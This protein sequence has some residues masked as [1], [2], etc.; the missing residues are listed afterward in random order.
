MKELPQEY[1][2]EKEAIREGYEKKV[3]KLLKPSIIT[4]ASALILSSFF[5]IKDFTKLK[6]LQKNSPIYLEY[7]DNQS[8]LKYLRNELNQ[9]QSEEF[10][11]FLSQNIKNELEEITVLDTTKIP[12]LEKLIKITE[13]DNIKI[14]N[15]PEFKEYLE[16]TEKI[17][18]RDYLYP[19]LLY[20]PM[21]TV[22][23]GDFFLCALYNGRRKK[24]VTDF[25][26]KYG[27]TQLS[28]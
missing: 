1:E 12:S 24:Q 22:F 17:D 20:G 4:L 16:K 8:S 5:M 2:Q 15:T 11:E 25:E 13:D 18:N 21:A 27:T 26:E 23:F 9:Y 7:V 10:P 14:T 19:L 6:G 3:R 28:Q